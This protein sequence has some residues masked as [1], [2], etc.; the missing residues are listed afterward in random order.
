MVRRLYIY[1]TW[2]QH[3]TL[4]LRV[5]T[6]P[7]EINCS[8]I[9][10]GDRAGTM[11]T[12]S[13]PGPVAHAKKGRGTLT[14]TPESVTEGMSYTLEVPWLRSTTFTVT[15]EG[16]M[17][18]SCEVFLEAFVSGEGVTNTAVAMSFSFSVKPVKNYQ[19][20]R[21]D[22]PRLV[23]G[24]LCSDSFR[25]SITPRTAELQKTINSMQRLYEE[26]RCCVEP[27][28]VSCF[29]SPDQCYDREGVSIF[30]GL[31]FCSG[32]DSLARVTIPCSFG[33]L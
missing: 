6:E 12:L 10:S 22:V 29:G 20:E 19:S 1:A 32:P 24:T 7:P 31:F 5:S 15:D 16:H 18:D 9:F 14:I 3:A 23:R 30:K 27:R 4:P 21:V 8:F 11:R 26:Q 2:P 33:G 17:T 28:S 25:D 13:L